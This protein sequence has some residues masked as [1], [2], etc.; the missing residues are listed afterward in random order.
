MP[1]NRTNPD[2]AH[3]KNRSGDL[4]DILEIRLSQ[5]EPIGDVLDALA[6]LLLDLPNNSRNS[7]LHDDAD[8]AD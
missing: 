6:T 4:E 8:A 3:P 1:V 7:R 5:E 2:N